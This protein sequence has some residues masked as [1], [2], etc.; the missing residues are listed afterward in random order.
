MAFIPEGANP[1]YAL[2][3][4]IVAKVVDESLA[5]KAAHKGRLTRQSL[6]QRCNHEYGRSYRLMLAGRSSMIAR[7]SLR[8]R[9]QREC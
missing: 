2:A 4:R 5:D 8:T 1:F 9:E 3:L 7:R 6:P